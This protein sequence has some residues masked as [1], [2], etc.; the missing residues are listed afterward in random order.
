MMQKVRGIVTTAHRA[1]IPASSATK[2]VQITRYNIMYICMY[3]CMYCIIC[4]C[5]CIL[6][7]IYVC[8][9]VY[10]YVFIYINVY[11]YHNIYILRKL[12]YCYLLV[13]YLPLSF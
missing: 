2:R 13:I 1:P 9:Y 8:M 7:N 5:V 6:H 12:A 11:T 10:T 3:V 4:A